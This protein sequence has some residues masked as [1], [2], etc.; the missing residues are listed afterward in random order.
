MSFK[1][2]LQTRQKAAVSRGCQRICGLTKGLTLIAALFFSAQAFAVEAHHPRLQAAYQEAIDILEG[3]S[4][5]YSDLY[6]YLI[7]P[8]VPAQQ[9]MQFY[10]EITG[11][12]GLPIRQLRG[13]E[14]TEYLADI[15]SRAL[16]GT[17]SKRALIELLQPRSPAQAQTSG[18]D[19]WAHQ[20]WDMR[21]RL[22]FMEHLASHRVSEE[23]F[24]L[25]QKA[26][27]A[28]EQ[29][30]QQN[31]SQDAFS[32]HAGLQ[33]QA[34]FG[35][36][37]EIV[38][39][40]ANFLF[41]CLNHILKNIQ[42]H[43]KNAEKT[44]FKPLK[45]LS[46][47]CLKAVKEASR[48][49]REL[50]GFG[51]VDAISEALGKLEPVVAPEWREGAGNW[52]FV[53]LGAL[54]PTVYPELNRIQA[55]FLRF[56]KTLGCLKFRTAALGDPAPRELEATVAVIAS[57][58]ILEKVQPLWQE[59]TIAILE[60]LPQ[61]PSP[62]TTVTATTTTPAASG[63]LSSKLFAARQANQTM[64]LRSLIIYSSPVWD[65]LNARLKRLKGELVALENAA[66]AQNSARVLHSQQESPPANTPTLTPTTSSSLQS[67]SPSV[68]S[69]FTQPGHAEAGQAQGGVMQEQGYGWQKSHLDALRLSEAVSEKYKLE[70]QRFALEAK[71]QALQ[72]GCMPP[73]EQELKVQVRL[74]EFFKGSQHRKMLEKIFDRAEN[75]ASLRFDELVAFVKGL[76]GEV[77]QRGGSHCTLSFDGQTTLRS[78]KGYTFRPHEGGE[79]T[80]TVKGFRKFLERAGISLASAGRE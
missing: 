53:D 76:G 47:K 63:G 70:L 11:Q 41:M 30:S 17:M 67:P 28:C 68:A 39:F 75:G 38:Q 36:R 60:S 2:R 29:A 73:T 74:T 49:A 10:L 16:Q 43:E 71:Q 69:S 52:S 59:L 9:K 27:K 48:S 21:S 72:T 13:P 23:G 33:Q 22:K 15:Q 44:L 12:A 32:Q 58:L 8:Q 51:E 6:L 14:L 77:T 1:H 20:Y 35:R 61:A 25:L 40:K 18:H 54:G 3:R 62:P 26:H 55:K 42:W 56:A 34:A 57:L 46:P 64:A 79:M 24:T 4:D 45:S 37:L 66:A 19:V 5:Y 80:A 78:A 65:Q 7:D 50:S 31:A